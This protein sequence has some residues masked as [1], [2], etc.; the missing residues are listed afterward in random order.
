MNEQ[1]IKAALE[2]LSQTGRVAFLSTSGQLLSLEVDQKPREYILPPSM[3]PDRLLRYLF[4]IDKELRNIYFSSLSTKQGP[5]DVQLRG[6]LER[7]NQAHESFQRFRESIIQDTREKLGTLITESADKLKANADHHKRQFVKSSRWL[8]AFVSI[9]L[10]ALITVI[11]GIEAALLVPFIQ[12]QTENARLKADFVQSERFRVQQEE[13]KS[14]RMRLDKLEKANL[15]VK[16][17]K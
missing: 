15:Q 8:V 2:P 13:M 1:E 7:V 10:V 16:Q 12:T 17:R 11:F 3:S 9:A 6:A 5:T 14:L 4:Q